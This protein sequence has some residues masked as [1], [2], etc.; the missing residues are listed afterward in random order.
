ML[1]QNPVAATMPLT[2]T[3]EAQQWNAVMSAIVEAPYRIVAPLVQS[4]TEQLQAQTQQSPATHGNG[5]DLDPPPPP[6]ESFLPQGD[7]PQ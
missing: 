7:K 5:L 2:V 1:T 6:A 3:L 4:I